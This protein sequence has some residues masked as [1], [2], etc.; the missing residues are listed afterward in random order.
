M[1]W[2]LDQTDK[3]IAPPRHTFID[4][5]SRVGVSWRSSYFSV[6]RRRQT[7]RLNSVPRLPPAA[8]P[9]GVTECTLRVGRFATYIV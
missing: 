5:M 3:L 8:R 7:Y 2:L 6:G 9:V 1:M 4:R